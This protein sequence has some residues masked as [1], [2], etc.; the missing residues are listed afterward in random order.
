MKTLSIIIPTYNVEK[1]LKRC[2][3]SIV[4]NEVVN[5]LEIIIVNDGGKDNSINIAKDY[6]KKYENS[7][8]IVDK[9]NGGH[10]SAINAGVQKATGKYVK[11]LDSDDWFNIDD[12]PNFVK[13]LRDIDCD[14]VITNYSREM[15]YTGENF[16]F[17]YNKKMEYNK[18]YEFDK[19][20]FKCLGLDY[21]TLATAT[22][23]NEILK[24]VPEKLDEKTFYVDMEFIIFPIPYI[25][26]FI[27][28]NY[29]IYR[30][31]IG[32]AEQSVNVNS[33]IKNKDHHERVLKRIIEFYNN[34]NV[35]ENKKKY[36]KNIIAQ[37]LNTHYMIFCLYSTNS[38]DKIQISKFDKFL[39]KAN[40]DLYNE[41]NNH[42]YIRWNRRTNFHLASTKKHLLTRFFNT[43]EY[44]MT[45]RKNKKEQ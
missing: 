27:Y 32:R 45:Y 39:N 17:K 16:N 2:L 14:I 8:I 21:F 25:K 42:A 18:V 10:G 4:L 34:N 41:M 38:K 40:I 13:D 26:N 9:E 28:L 20:N 37:M 24:S 43:Y 22:Y 5:D 1:Y 29:N 31:Y 30:Y 36:I 6:K 33:M 11:I 12:F 35:S 44:K 19:F 15:V 7:I 3:D 23:K